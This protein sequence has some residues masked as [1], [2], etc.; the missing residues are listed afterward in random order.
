MS[1]LA[2]HKQDKTRH[3]EEHYK[4]DLQCEELQQHIIRTEITCAYL[5][6]HITEHL[7]KIGVGSS[8]F[9]LIDDFTNL[10]CNNYAYHQQ[11]SIRKHILND[12]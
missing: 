11:N 5:I 12:I 6:L 10:S 7:T 9:T 1:Y 2:P 4:K 8:K 3:S